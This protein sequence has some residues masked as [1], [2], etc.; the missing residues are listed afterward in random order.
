MH[1]VSGFCRCLL[2]FF[3]ALRLR[4]SGVNSGLSLVVSGFS[5]R[6]SCFEGQVARQPL[7]PSMGNASGDKLGR[8]WQTPCTFDSGH[9]EPAFS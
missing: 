5:L 3:V 4:K 7:N 8:R 2:C 6:T 1:W 9:E